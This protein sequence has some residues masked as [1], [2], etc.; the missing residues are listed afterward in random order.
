MFN[1]QRFGLFLT[2]V[3][4]VLFSVFLGVKF[5]FELLSC[6]VALV[7]TYVWVYF[8]ISWY[9]KVYVPVTPSQFGEEDLVKINALRTI[10]PRDLLDLDHQI[11]YVE[12][13]SGSPNSAEILR[14]YDGLGHY[15]F[16]VSD[17]FVREGRIIRPT[18]VDYRMLV[19]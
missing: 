18:H 4:S 6:F 17:A 19:P 5:G 7:L 10:Q 16:H 9:P 8:D 1:L 2:F 15:D 14:L 13:V 3:L 12:W 11:F